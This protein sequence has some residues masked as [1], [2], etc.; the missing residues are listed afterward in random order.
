MFF[1]DELIALRDQSK[2]H[3]DA[4]KDDPDASQRDLFSGM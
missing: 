3:A 2:A 1:E 4:F